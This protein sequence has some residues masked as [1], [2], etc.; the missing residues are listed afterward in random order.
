MGIVASLLGNDLGAF[1]VKMKPHFG[2]PGFSH[3]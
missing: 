3:D 2:Q 1:K